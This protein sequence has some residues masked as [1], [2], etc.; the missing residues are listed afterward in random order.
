MSAAYF[1]QAHVGQNK[2]NHRRRRFARKISQQFIWRAVRRWLVPAHAQPFGNG[3]EA[4]FFFMAASPAAPIPRL[5]HKGAMRRIHQADNSL[6][7]V[8][9]KL[10]RQ[11]RDLVFFAED[12]KLWRLRYVFR[13]PRT[14]RGHINPNIS[15]VFGAWI[16]SCENPLYAQF[17][18]ACK[19]R[20]LQASPAASVKFPAVVA[21]FHRLPIK[22]PVRQRDSSMRTK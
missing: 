11:P 1:F 9:G 14:R 17:I 6:I 10:A 22:S 20:N 18:L 8:R 16:M 12:R 4:L 3:P 13:S 7:H 2:I 15:I 21:A 19:R 5:M